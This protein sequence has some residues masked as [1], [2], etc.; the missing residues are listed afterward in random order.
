MKP[1]SIIITGASSGIGTALALVYAQE[2]STLLLMGRNEQKLKHL[3]QKCEEQGAK[4]TLAICDV[5]DSP[6]MKKH[7]MAFD[8]KHTTDLVIAN[9]GIGT[10][11]S[12]QKNQGQSDP[13]EIIDT[14]ILG[15]HATIEPLIPLMKQRKR[16]Q[17]ALMSSLASYRGF[18]KYYVYNATKAYIRIYGQGLRLDLKRYN[19]E[20]ST[21]APG[22]VKTPL[23]DCNNFKMPLIMSTQKAA[24][25]IQ[26]GLKKNKS[27]IAFPWIFHFLVRF[28]AALPISLADKIAESATD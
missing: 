2:G 10:G 27:I 5:C 11:Q 20:V 25:I 21:I 3:A 9:A 17:I 14:N 28:I 19:I 26:K 22:F 7:I 6:E 12:A 13:L 18:A 15:V 4:V 16:G 8:Q 23:T 24:K 1:T